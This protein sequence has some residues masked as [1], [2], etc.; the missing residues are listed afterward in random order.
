MNYKL[1]IITFIVL[2]IVVFIVDYYLILKKRLNLINNKG[3]TKKGKK[4]KVKSIEEIDYMVIKFKLSE[5][6]INKN[7]AIRDIALINSFII[8][9]VS[10]ILMIVPYKL[11]W[12]MLIAFVLLLGLIY[13]LYELYGRHLKRK[14]E[15]EN[16]D[17]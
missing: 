7:K 14:E 17:K 16:G 1:A 8:A 12:Q 6:K 11:I 5:K 9:I 4:K 13:S 15:R 3:K 10:S 2:F